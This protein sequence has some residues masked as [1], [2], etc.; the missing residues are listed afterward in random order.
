MW[1]KIYEHF[2][3]LLTDGQT[4]KQMDSQNDYSAHLRGV[5]FYPDGFSH[6]VD[7]LAHSICFLKGSLLNHDVF[8]SWRFVFIFTTSSVACHLGPR[9]QCL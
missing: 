3:Y 1:F 6:A 9:L 8:L 4:D 5:Q 7:R 2:H